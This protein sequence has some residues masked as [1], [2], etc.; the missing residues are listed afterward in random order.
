MAVF[1][2]PD[3]NEIMVV[4]DSQHYLRSPRPEQ[5]E[6]PERAEPEPRCSMR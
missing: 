5:P 1:E 2:D 4:E 6:R 3:G